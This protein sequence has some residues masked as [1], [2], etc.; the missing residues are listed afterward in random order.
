MIKLIYMTLCVSALMGCSKRTHDAPSSSMEPKLPAGSKVTIDYAAY[1]SE[2]LARFDIVA[3]RPPAPQNAIFTFRVVGLPGEA[4]Q[5]TT[6]AVLIDGMAVAHPD[7][8]KYIPAPSGINKVNLARSAY[9]LLGDNTARARDSRYLG[10]IDGSQILGKVIGI[11]QP[12]AEVQS[13]GAPSD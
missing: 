6:D 9:F 11:E 12:D 10:P 7:G 13:E 1:R 8:L 4:I 3:F 5:L 2:Q